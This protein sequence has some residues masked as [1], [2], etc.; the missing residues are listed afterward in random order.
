MGNPSTGDGRRHQERKVGVATALEDS[1]TNA[2]ERPAAGGS[3]VTLHG[4]ALGEGAPERVCLAPWGD[5]TS[6]NGA[7]TVDEQSAREVVAA[8]KAHGTELPIDYEHQS[9]GGSYASP[10]GQAPAAGWIRELHVVTPDDAREGEIAGLWAEVTWTEAARAKLAA[11]EYRYI[12]P[13][14]IVRKDDRRV[15]ALHS[16]A[17]TNKPA[18]VGMTPLVHR[19]QTETPETTASELT[20]AEAEAVEAIRGELGLSEDAT[21]ETIL[22]AAKTQLAELSCERR[23]HEAERRVEQAMQTGKLMP[24]QRRWALELAMHDPDAF[25]NWAASAPVVIA[26][27]RVEPPDS[28]DAGSRNREAVIASARLRFRSEPVLSQL[29]TEQAWIQLTLREAGLEPSDNNTSV[30]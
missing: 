1:Q 14:V 28:P 29:T 2:G 18:I 17:L 25:D 3:Q 10:N 27:G 7:F 22:L 12:S 8:F 16:A 30:R 15:V 9:L 21:R 24:R 23:V 19:E 20:P 5:V 4:A 6:T 26:P 13:V 11:R